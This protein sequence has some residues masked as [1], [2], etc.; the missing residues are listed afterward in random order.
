MSKDYIEYSEAQACLDSSN[1]S[2]PRH[3][4]E[5][6]NV[7]VPADSKPYIAVQLGLAPVA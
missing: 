3:G 1:Q 5:N 2:V 6:R 7:S 4:I